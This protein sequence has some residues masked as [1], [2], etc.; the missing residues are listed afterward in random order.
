MIK[1]LYLHTLQADSTENWNAFCKFIVLDNHKISKKSKTS[2][3]RYIDNITGSVGNFVKCT[4]IKSGCIVRVSVFFINRSV[5][6]ITTMSGCDRERNVHFLLCCF[7]LVSRCTLYQPSHI[8]L[9]CTNQEATSTSD[10]Q[11]VNACT[12]ARISEPTTV[13][14]FKFC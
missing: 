2:V 13:F 14:S 8:I 10:T 5:V 6:L 9:L 12:C 4:F 3:L 11:A 7:D 1:M